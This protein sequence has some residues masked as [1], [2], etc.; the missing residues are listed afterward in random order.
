MHEDEYGKW[1]NRKVQLEEIAVIIQDAAH[2]ATHAATR[3]RLAKLA[4][5]CGLLLL[6]HA[7]LGFMNH[8]PTHL[9]GFHLGV[10]IVLGVAAV[11]QH[12]RRRRAIDRLADAIRD[13][14]AA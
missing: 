5:T 6:V 10:S 12:D 8:W 2:A 1:I 9:F 13:R 7:I 11:L 14:E 3:T 4:T